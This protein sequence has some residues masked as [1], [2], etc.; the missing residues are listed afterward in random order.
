M[1]F[2]Y[3]ATETY[4]PDYDAGRSSWSKYLEFSRL[5]HLTELV[6]L[7]GMLNG[8][9]FEPDRGDPGDWKFIVLHDLYE[10]L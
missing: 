9:L 7:D 8:R 3:T 6:S 10:I 1:I 5:T 2:L 4:G